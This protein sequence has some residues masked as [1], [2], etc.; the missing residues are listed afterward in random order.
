MCSNFQWSPFPNGGYKAEVKV[1]FSKD[2]TWS[3]CLSLSEDGFWGGSVFVNGV[4]YVEHFWAHC[5]LALD[6]PDTGSQLLNDRTIQLPEFPNGPEKFSCCDGCLCQSCGVLC[7]AQQQLDGCIM[8]IWSLEAM[9][10]GW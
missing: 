10:G 3:S 8:R 7:Y 1:F 4:L 6:A 9:T 2:S 5:L